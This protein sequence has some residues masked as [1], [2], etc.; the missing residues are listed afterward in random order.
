MTHET[1]GAAASTRTL[2]L[3]AVRPPVIAWSW[4]SPFAVIDG[5]RHA[6]A[7]GSQSF[8]IASDRPVTVQC[9]QSRGKATGA[10]ATA[11]LLPEHH[12]ELDYSP[13]ATHW[14]AAEIGAPG[15]TRTRGTWSVWLAL[16]LFV[17]ILGV[18]VGYV[19]LASTA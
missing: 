17:A 10:R 1:P 9:E 18:A 12:A 19:V 3:T 7:W 6:L 14:F 13:S 8:T 2:T 11:V 16:G 4:I 15:T 5:V